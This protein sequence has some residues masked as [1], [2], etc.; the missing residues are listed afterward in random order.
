MK[1]SI[2][3]VLLLSTVNPV[4]KD[5]GKKIV[6]SGLCHF[7][8]EIVGHERFLFATTD[9]AEPR[10]DWQFVQLSR[11]TVMERVWN[12]VVESFLLSR[13]SIQES[14]FLS[15]RLRRDILRLVAEFRPDIVVF[16]TV[17]MGQYLEAVRVG[18]RSVLYLDDL[19]SVRYERMLAA[20][21]SDAS[22]VP[23]AL[24][25]FAR[26]IPRI[27]RPL[28]EG[29]GRVLRY[30]LDVER[31]LVRRSEIR[32]AKRADTTLL[33]NREEVDLLKG[34]AVGCDVRECPPLL[35][36]EE[37]V[38]RKWDG[39]P[40]FVFLGALNLPHNLSAIERFLSGSFSKLLDLVPEARLCIV[41]RGAPDSL[42]NL[43]KRF[44]EHVTLAGFV[45]DV[46]KL[47]AQSCALIAPLIFGSGTKIKMIE[48]LAAGIP[49]VAT[50]IGAEGINFVHGRH[51]FIVDDLEQ[52]PEAMLRLADPQINH[53]YSLAC[54]ELFLSD[55]S[56][57][58]VRRKYR[59]IF[60]LEWT[61]TPEHV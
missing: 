52:F 38:E 21:Q 37:P 8:H 17:R 40:D 11:P 28:V 41:G 27:A 20:A 49:V 30:L 16:D 42:I 2:P 58:S 53:G 1:Q 44:G 54:R 46:R 60:R 7:L 19:F 48:A 18:C 4:A 13:R 25:N 23:N 59:E 29:N 47:L 3:R 50:R 5:V 26:H 36:Y 12:T 45:P 35:S 39:A 9:D 33:I 6:I 15:D 14:I 56:V 34:I 51:G 57:E 10:A 31:R 43:A 55:Y 61:V 32:Q 22:A 24:G